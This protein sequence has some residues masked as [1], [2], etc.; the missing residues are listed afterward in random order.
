MSVM[1]IKKLTCFI[2]VGGEAKRL[3][4]LTSDVSKPCIRF[5][6]KPLI[7]FP[8]AK[9]AEQGLRNFIFGEKGYTNYINLFDMYGEGFGF[10]TKYNIK[11]KIC[12]RHQ[13]NFDDL[14]SADSYRL[15]MEYYNVQDPVLVIQGDNLFEIDLSNFIR[16]H[17]EKEAK[18][19]KAV[20]T[21]ALIKVENVEEYGIA[22]VDDNCQITKFREKP[23][24]NETPSKLANTG[25]YL[26][27][28]KT[29]R[30]FEDDNVKKMIENGRLDFG[31]DMIPYLVNDEKFAVYGYELTKWYD[32]GNPQMYLKAMYDV[33][34]GA[35]DIRLPGE[36]IFPERTITG[37]SFAPKDIKRSEK[38]IMKYSEKEI[39]ID[40]AALIG[41]HTKIGVKSRISDSN[42]DNFCILGDHVTVEKSAIMDA[43]KIM[44][45]ACIQNSIIGRKVI[46]ESTKKDCTTIIS[47][48]VI[49]NGV[50]IKQGCKLVG[51]KVYPSLTISPNKEYNNDIIF[52]ERFQRM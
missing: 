34:H 14:G 1:D 47:N 43:T 20:L 26:L 42:I 30:K 12:I 5:L 3:K 19:K 38:I 35:L 8:M 11:H 29:R 41:M 46:V 31:F 32:I 48:S 17:E 49:G 22:E 27:S 37:Q 40:E 39:T 44:D 21:I 28:P 18:E 10:S 6:N 24:E 15:N 33:L 13:P 45:Y 52:E 2:P 25:I 4:P 9:L 7:E 23:N 50:H 16:W 51:T 36:R